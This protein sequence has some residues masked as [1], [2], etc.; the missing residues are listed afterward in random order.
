MRRFLFVAVTVLTAAGPN[1]A[2]AQADLYCLKGG[3]WGWPGLCQFA[4]Y[5]QCLAT[6][7]GTN[8]YC[9]TNPRYAY[10]SYRP[11]Y[12]YPSQRPGYWQGY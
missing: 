5:Q 6:A 1:P 11:G 12:A 7:S 3:D 2:A 9:G 8:S 10:S 4:S